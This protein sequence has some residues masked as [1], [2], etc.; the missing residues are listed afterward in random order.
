MRWSGHEPSDDKTVAER[1]RQPA[2]LAPNPELKGK[3][4]AP[5]TLAEHKR[6]APRPARPEDSIPAVPP[7]GE[8]T[9]YYSDL[10]PDT[11]DV[12]AYPTQQKVN[13]ETF[14]RVCSQCHTLARAINAPVVSGAFWRFYMMS[15]RARARTARRVELTPE[16]YEEILDFLTYD[17]QDRKVGRANQFDALTEELKKRFEA[18]LASRQRRLEAAP[19]PPEP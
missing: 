15:M 19:P 16:Q 9:L 18:L 4:P 12:S 1:L 11:I 7:G 17:A 3:S 10:G 14:H 8:D 2:D 5:G 13:Y 6:E